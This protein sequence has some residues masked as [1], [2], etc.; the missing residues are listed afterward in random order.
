MNR[1]LFNQ[2]LSRA[3]LPLLFP[4]ATNFL[5]PDKNP[6]DRIGMST[7][8]FRN[9]FQ[10]TRPENITNPGTDLTLKEIPGYFRDRFQLRNVEFWSKHFESIDR[11]YLKELKSAIK[12]S[13]S[14][15]IN[16]Q[17]DESYQLGDPDPDK[18][19]ESLAL[20]LRWVEAAKMLGSGAIRVNP[21]QGDLMEVIAALKVVNREAKRK[22]L[23]LMTENHFGM[24]MDPDVHLKI[25]RE[26]GENMYTL[27]DY[28]NYPD[29]VRYDA[30]K[31]IMPFAYQVSAKTIEFSNNVDHLSFD[32]E[33]CM[34]LAQNSGFKGIYSIE[35]WSPTPIKVSEE[36][37]A[38]WMIEKVKPFCI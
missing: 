25:V 31:K 11:S 4:S 2:V 28:G 26:V 27:P 23:I 10:N 16:I 36:A 29:E 21:G 9:R 14:K 37:M 7:V 32:F 24:E 33:R 6:M 1:R 5:P 30:L 8:N 35:Q 34:Q 22:G 15:L 20:V 38:D 12:R 13:R 19:R 17:L 18:R 3:S